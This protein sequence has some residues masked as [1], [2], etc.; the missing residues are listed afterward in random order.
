MVALLRDSFLDVLAQIE[1]GAK[2]REIGLQLKIEN[3]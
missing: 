1:T 2:Q 3:F